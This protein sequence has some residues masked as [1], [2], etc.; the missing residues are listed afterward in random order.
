M[1]NLTDMRK[2]GKFDREFKQ[3]VIE[4][5]RNR[6]DIS[7]L[8]SELDISADRIYRWRRESEIH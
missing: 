6:E 4:L 2:R 5:S 1:L 8:A 3:M 7:A